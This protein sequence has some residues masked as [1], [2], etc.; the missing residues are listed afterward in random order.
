MNEDNRDNMSKGVGYHIA[1]ISR[2]GSPGEPPPQQEVGGGLEGSHQ[3][4]MFLFNFLITESTFEGAKY[5]VVYDFA[6]SF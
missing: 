4:A 3:K 2:T 1:T 6:C 5:H